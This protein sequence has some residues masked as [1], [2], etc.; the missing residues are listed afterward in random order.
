MLLYLIQCNEE[1]FVEKLSGRKDVAAVLQRLG[2]LTQDEGRVT[3][4]QIFVVVYG[5]A[6]TMRVVMDSEQIP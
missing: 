2:R 5:L 6:L 4:A 3:A 1:K